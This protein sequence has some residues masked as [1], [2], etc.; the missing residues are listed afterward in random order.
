MDLLIPALV[1]L[2]NY[3]HDLATAFFFVTTLYAW[4]TRACLPDA[5]PNL[6]RNLKR[7]ALMSFL[8]ILLLGVVRTIHYRTYEWFPALERSQVTILIGKH[9]VLAGITAWA[10]WAWWKMGRSSW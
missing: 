2:N 7:L 9:V 3:L 1:Y 6:F 8:L 5:P 4:W 10:G